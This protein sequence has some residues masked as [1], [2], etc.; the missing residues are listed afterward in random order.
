MVLQFPNRAVIIEYSELIGC[1][2][3]EF[4]N[5]F[6]EYYLVQQFSDPRN[7]TREEFVCTLEFRERENAERVAAWLK[8]N[9]FIPVGVGSRSLG[10]EQRRGLPG[11][12][13]SD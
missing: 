4:L 8:G 11:C 6:L 10:G 3:A 9:Y 13:R 1:K 5:R 7:G 2:P 12:G